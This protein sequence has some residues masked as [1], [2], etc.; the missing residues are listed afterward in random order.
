ML[1]SCGGSAGNKPR[2][3]LPQQPNPANATVTTDAPRAASAL[4]RGSGGTIEATGGD[5]T[6]YTLTVPPGA[7]AA[8]TTI[9]MVPVTG[10]SGLDVRGGRFLGVQLEPDGLRLFGD[11]TLRISP[12]QGPRHS[13]V[14]FSYHGGGTEIHRVPL[15]PSL[16]LLQLHLLHFSGAL[17]YVGDN[18][19][20]SPAVENIAPSEWEDRILSYIE[21]IIRDDR[22]RA[23]RGEKPDPN[24]DLH[25][26]DAFQ[27]YYELVIQPS[28]ARMTT[29]CSFAHT[30][31]P[32][33][34]AWE[35]N[36]EVWGFHDRFAAQEGT[37]MS[38]VVQALENCFDQTK[39]AC[40]DTSNA[41][42]MQ[43]AIGYTRQLALFGMSDPAYD[44]LN[45]ALHCSTGW[46]GTSTSTL[47]LN[48]TALT[49]IVDANVQWELNP[50]KTVLG[51]VTTWRVKAG[52]MTWEEKG[53]DAFG[54]THQ[55]GPVSFD[56][57]AADGEMVFDEVSRTYQ[58][59]GAISQF[60]KVDVKCPAGQPS[61]TAD[62][63]VGLW[64][65]TPVLPL[66]KNAT[67]LSGT[68]DPAGL[69]TTYAWQF[70]R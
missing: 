23:L 50:A 19:F 25:L 67:A 56:L 5:G 24:R 31:T 22:E 10:V 48:G 62:A 57:T 37:V 2:A 60:T 15:T 68:Y 21:T 7:L 4:V 20:I 12:P 32:R 26:I 6:V 52:S 51:V 55:G 64:L 34:F 39:G 1:F 17:V 27:G 41:A 44:A 16:D 46:T 69:N 58:A 53:A 9:T 14:G 70:H 29:D 49:D 61:Y 18:I 40:L 42:Q 65:L 43:E 54:C 11:V 38:A 63:S 66:S 45:P 36:V 13:A 35:H 33:A 47:R 30:A 59:T 28:L 3:Q 8:D